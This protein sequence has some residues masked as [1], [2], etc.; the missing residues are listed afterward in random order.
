MR[1]SFF[2]VSSSATTSSTAS[3]VTLG[4]TLLMTSL[5]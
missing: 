2:S 5:N 3:A 4:H 1:T